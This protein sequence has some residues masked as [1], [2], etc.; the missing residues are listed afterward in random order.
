MMYKET[1]KHGILT[2]SVED[3]WKHEDVGMLE[4]PVFYHATD[5]VHAS[6]VWI[7]M[8]E[9]PSAAVTEAAFWAKNLERSMT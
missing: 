9:H 5:G 7:G 8:N 6:A 4:V 2:V 3:A 1:R